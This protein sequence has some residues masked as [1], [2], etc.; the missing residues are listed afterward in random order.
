M[1]I[2]KN[3]LVTKAIDLLSG[4]LPKTATPLEKDMVGTKKSNPKLKNLVPYLVGKFALI[5]SNVSY[6]ELKTAVESEVVM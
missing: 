6:T 5:F 1:I 4:P 2:A 3:T